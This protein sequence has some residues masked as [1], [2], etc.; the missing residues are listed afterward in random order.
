[1]KFRKSIE[2]L[3]TPEMLRAGKKTPRHFAIRIIDELDA[4]RR[5]GRVVDEYGIIEA[6][7]IDALDEEEA[8]IKLFGTPTPGF[9][10]NPKTGKVEKIKGYGLNTSAKIAKRKAAKKSKLKLT[11]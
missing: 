8:K 2:H 6:G 4:A 10:L 5:S 1:M 11:R 7:I 9:K 3:V